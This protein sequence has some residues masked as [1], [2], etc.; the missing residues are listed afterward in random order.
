MIK[1]V[2]DSSADLSSEIL[3][4]LDVSVVPLYVRF[5]DESYRERV[6]ISDEDFYKKLLQGTVHPTTSQPNPQ[7]LVEIYQKLAEEA[8]AIVSIHISSKLSGT[9]NSAFQAKNMLAS[10]CPVEIIDSQTITVELGSIVIAAA[11]AAQ[12]GKSLQQVLEATKEAMNNAHSLV[13]LDTLKYLRLG[14][15]IGK[16]KALL[17]SVLNVKPMIS[18]KGGEVVPVGQVRSRSKGIERLVNSVKDA[19]N[20][21]D[22]AVAYSTT[23]EDAQAISSRIAPMFT[24]GKIRLARLGTT[25]GVHLGPG[26]IIVFFRE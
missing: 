17:G 21:Q 6:D 23:L 22:L 7:D 9:L 8:E 16:G 11:K 26:T 4:A 19:T 12:E 2:T 15:R 25:L 5:G 1:I 14:G 13:L 10:K 3:S 24:T 20:I 18:I